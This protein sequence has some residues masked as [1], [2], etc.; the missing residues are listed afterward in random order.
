[1]ISLFDKELLRMEQE[2]RDLKTIHQRGLGTVKFFETETTAT[3]TTSG[4]IRFQ[5]NIA[6]DEPANPLAI[7]LV[8]YPEPLQDIR[9]GLDT[10]GLT[11]WIGTWTPPKN[12]KIKFISSSQLSGITQS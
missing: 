1:M 3:L 2:V 9:I 5:G 4:S 6:T 7:S 11:R 8:N 10:V 12:I